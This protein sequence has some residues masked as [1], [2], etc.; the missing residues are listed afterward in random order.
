MESEQN[1]N[2]EKKDKDKD[3]DDFTLKDVP[4]DNKERTESGSLSRRLSWG[5]NMSQSGKSIISKLSQQ[6]T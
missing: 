2:D 3:V 5:R 4:I 6:T 1:V